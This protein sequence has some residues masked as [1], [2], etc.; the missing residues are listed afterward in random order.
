MQKSNIVFVHLPDERAPEIVRALSLGANRYRIIDIPRVSARVALFDLVEARKTSERRIDFV[1]VIEPSSYWT[2]SILTVGPPS[3]ND[4][5]YFEELEAFVVRRGRL[6]SL[7]VHRRRAAQ[8]VP[9]IDEYSRQ[10]AWTSCVA[11]QRV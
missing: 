6:I 10:R 11:L 8:T 7:A 3:P 2:I 4:L 5:Q 9:L 1:R